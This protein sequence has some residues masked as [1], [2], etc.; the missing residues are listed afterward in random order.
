MAPRHCGSA[1][2]PTWKEECF[3]LPVAG[4]EGSGLESLLQERG[5]WLAAMGML[6]WGGGIGL[7]QQALL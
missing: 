4:E 2:P 3:C 5:I 7:I 6:G 1:L